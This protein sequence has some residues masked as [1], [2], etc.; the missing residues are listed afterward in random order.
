M[1]A[2]QLYGS[3][4]FKSNLVEP[5]LLVLSVYGSI[6]YSSPEAKNKFYLDLSGSFQSMRSPEVVDIADDFAT[7][8]GH[9]TKMECPKEARFPPNPIAPISEIISAKF[10]LTTE[11]FWR[12]PIFVT[13]GHIGLSSVHCWA[14]TDYIVISCWLPDSLE[15]SD[16]SGHT[17]GLRSCFST[18]LHLF[19]CSLS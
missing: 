1:C 19:A 17:S 8:P 12:I 13:Q 9:S 4:S 10:I 16:H 15:D 14:Q 7:K 2:F 11:C 3:V 18:C 5:W 6:D